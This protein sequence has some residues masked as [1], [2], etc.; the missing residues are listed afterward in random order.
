[1]LTQLTQEQIDLQAKVRD[2]W[3]DIA[4]HQKNFD[5]EELEA[6]VKWLYY[7]ASLKEPKVVFVTGPKDFA[8]KLGASVRDSVRDSVGASVRASVMDSVRA[9]VMDSVWASVWASV[10]A[11]VR[12]SVAWTSLNGDSEFGAYYEYYKKIGVVKNDKADKYVGFLRAG[13]FYCMFFEKVAYVM[14]RPIYVEQDDRKR[15]H[16][17][18]RPAL[19]FKDGTK[20]YKI[21]GVTFDK[22]WWDKIRKDKLS[23]DEVFA[24]DNVE[25]RRIAYEYMDKT[26]MKKL[27]DYKVLDERLDISGNKERIVSFTVQNMKEPLKFLNVICPTGREYFLGTNQ[28][29]CEKAQKA[30]LGLENEQVEFVKRW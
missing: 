11:S 17:I 2:E 14:Q 10:G 18:T 16:S 24:I 1:M 13:A 4:L 8:K 19:E 23:P 25:H 26:K 6:G 30:L 28:D 21:N 22:K 7:S 5:K 9:S 20:I 12:D 27:K 3:I 29:T 15:L